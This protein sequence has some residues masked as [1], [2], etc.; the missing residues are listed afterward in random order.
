MADNSEFKEVYNVW[1]FLAA[2]VTL[3]ALPLMHIV[4]GW[5]TFVISQ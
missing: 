3:L 1:Y 5:Y 2:V 4:L